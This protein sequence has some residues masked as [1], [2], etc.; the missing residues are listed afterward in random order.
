MGIECAL[1]RFNYRLCDPNGIGVGKW[2]VIAQVLHKGRL[3]A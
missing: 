1:D 3:L 2:R